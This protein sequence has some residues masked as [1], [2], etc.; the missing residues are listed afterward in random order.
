[1]L[2]ASGMTTGKTTTRRTPPSS[3]RR[4]R[5]T[6]SPHPASPVVPGIAAARNLMSPHPASPVVPGTAAAPAVEPG[7]ALTTSQHPTTPGG[8]GWRHAAEATHVS[9]WDRR[10]RAGRTRSSAH[11]A[12]TIRTG[13]GAHCAS[14][15]HPGAADAT[16]RR[17]TAASANGV[18]AWGHG[19]SHSDS[20]TLTPHA[21]SD[22]APTPSSAPLGGCAASS[23]RLH[24]RLR[25][26]R[27]TRTGGRIRPV[28]AWTSCRVAQ[29]RRRHS[30]VRRTT[31]WGLWKLAPSQ[32]VQA[33][34]S[35][36]LSTWSRFPQGRLSGPRQ[37]ASGS[38]ALVLLE[39]SK[40]PLAF[41]V[42]LTSSDRGAVHYMLPDWSVRPFAAQEL[43]CKH[44]FSERPLLV[45]QDPTHVH[46]CDAN[47]C[48]GVAR[49]LPVWVPP[50]EHPMH[51]ALWSGAGLG[52][53]GKPASH[54][55]I[56]SGDGR[57]S[58]VACGRLMTVPDAEAA[59]ISIGVEALTTVGRSVRARFTS[60]PLGV[61]PSGATIGRVSRLGATAR[62]G[63]AGLD[64]AV[65]GSHTGF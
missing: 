55:A 32:M 3:C 9:G 58:V 29:K 21:A 20:A 31:P 49:W 54:V 4:R 62:L 14:S 24:Y 60:V 30:S 22:S 50:V 45:V 36:S 19:E 43:N 28:S 16:L 48:D 15:A 63:R 44:P 6:I 42:R 65:F 13:A 61:Q 46:Q 2:N 35:G 12:R 41:L 10:P 38:R 39:V 33:R 17:A 34:Q 26:L 7:S 64:R 11:T 47:A 5:I 53:A 40:S 51:R 1:M 18:P 25:H 37:P 27:R 59:G 56:V 8:L 23:H 57:C 52:P